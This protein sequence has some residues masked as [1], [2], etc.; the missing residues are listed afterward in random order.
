MDRTNEMPDMLGLICGF[1]AGLVVSKKHKYFLL[2]MRLPTPTADLGQGQYASVILVQ[3][4][5]A[6]LM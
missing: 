2:T 5:S 4:S 1:D 6:L 3:F